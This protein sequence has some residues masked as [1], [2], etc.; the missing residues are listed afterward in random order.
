MA[1]KPEGYIEV[2]DRIA[3]FYER[4]PNGVIQT[5][6]WDQVEVAGQVFIVVQ[7]RVYREPSDALFGVGTAWEQYPGRTPF[8]RGTELMNCETSSWGRALASIGLAGRHI[9]TVEDLTANGTVK[10]S[11][12][13]SPAG[14]GFVSWTA[15]EKVPADKIKLALGAM[16]IAFGNKRLKT[17]VASLSDEQV[18]ILRERLSV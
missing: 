2:A 18:A 15:K 1:G 8:T 16:G 17:I 5:T 3:A 4:Y 12:V 14:Q 6:G 10:P 9:A 7:S 13:L 11:N